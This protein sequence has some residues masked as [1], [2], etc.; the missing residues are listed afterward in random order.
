MLPSAYKINYSGFDV[1]NNKI[2]LYSFQKQNNAFVIEN[3]LISE[4][5]R[6]VFGILWETA[7]KYKHL[8]Q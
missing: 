8:L 5:M 1:Y 7:E 3:N 2:I 6:T 4:M